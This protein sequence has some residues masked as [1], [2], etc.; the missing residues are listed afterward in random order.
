M[1]SEKSTKRYY[2]IKLKQD[3]FG[4]K[5]VKKLRRLAGG[6]T[7]TIIF[8]KLQLLSLNNNGIIYFD[9]LEINFAEE[10]ALEIDEDPEN[11]QVT[12]AYLLKVGWIEE[13]NTENEIY[14]NLIKIEVG[15]ETGSATRMRDFRNRQKS[16]LSHCDKQVTASDK[17][18]TTEQESE[19]EL[20]KE[21]QPGKNICCVV[22]NSIS[23]QDVLATTQKFQL[24]E[25]STLSFIQKYG[26]ESVYKQL[27]NLKQTPNIRNNGAWLHSALEKNYELAP[28][29]NSPVADTDCQTCHGTGKLEL[30]VDDTGEIISR[31]CSCLQRRN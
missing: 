14:Y 16:I 23:V 28:S 11:V 18:V 20:D 25:K 9:G 30:R 7:Y 24:S 2:W 6:D 10:I 27:S 8:L 17:I 19:L 3:F 31:P 4:Q 21:Q 29:A 5:E 12:I 26:L 13:I 1:A 15:S 22:D